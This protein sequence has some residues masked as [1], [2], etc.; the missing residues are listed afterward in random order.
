[1]CLEQESGQDNYESSESRQILAILT[2]KIVCGM[3]IEPCQYRT[4]L[5]LKITLI[6]LGKSERIPPVYTGI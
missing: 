4:N 5:K 3:D 2:I 6:T 1:M